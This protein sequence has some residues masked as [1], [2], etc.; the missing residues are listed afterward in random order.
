[1]K[2]LIATI[3]ILSVNFSVNA[4]R[5]VQVD[6]IIGISYVQGEK[7]PN[8][9]RKEALNEAKI[10]ALR[11]AGIGESI[12]AQELL[13]TSEVNGD[14]SNFFNSSSQIEIKGAVKSYEI[15]GERMYCLDSLSVVYE[16]I[17][18][19]TVI[20][21]NKMSDPRFT[22]S[23]EGIKSVYE[24]NSKLEFSLKSTQ[25]S[26]LTIFNITDNEAYVLYP[27]SYEMPFELDKLK[28][29]HFPMG[30]L[31]YELTNTSKVVETN[32]LI[33]VF[34]KKPMVYIKMNS[35][36]VT[37]IDEV[38]SWIYSISP[39]QRALEYHSYFVSN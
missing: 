13:F 12:S 31:N 8:Q 27:N 25:S 10:E 36:Q 26:F 19:A 3:I 28:D 23:V 17:I 15:I 33:F 39:D 6:N 38:F 30:E 14:F 11:K 22:A 5:D 9:A 1:M 2:N 37:T 24:S 16:V 34:T 18:N 4:S 20:K 35:E 32:R 21:Y 29:Y 7:S